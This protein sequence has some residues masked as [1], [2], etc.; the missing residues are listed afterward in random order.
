MPLSVTCSCLCELCEC[1]HV[2]CCGPQVLELK[3]GFD[4]ILSYSPLAMV[5]FEIS[6]FSVLI[7]VV[8]WWI[9]PVSSTRSSPLARSRR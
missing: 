5:C 3:C 6:Y 1:V 2:W 9:R 7:L 8:A 4:V